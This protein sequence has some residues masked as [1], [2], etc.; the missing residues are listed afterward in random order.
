MFTIQAPAKAYRQAHFKT[1]S[2]KLFMC[3]KKARDFANDKE[4]VLS[5]DS[6]KDSSNDNKPPLLQIR[7]G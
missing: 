4:I 1:A 7:F 6:W 3:W 5:S 2:C